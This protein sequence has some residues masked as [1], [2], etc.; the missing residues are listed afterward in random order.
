MRRGTGPTR[1]FFAETA[2]ADLDE[3]HR[4]YSELE[5]P[6]IADRLLSEIVRKVEQL[7]THPLSGRVVPEF[8]VDSLREVI[9]PPFR[10][11]YRVDPG[12]VR[13]VRVWRS[14]RRFDAPQASR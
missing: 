9:V 10:V 3:M 6:D 5:L 7:A 11:V 14:E 1:I 13:I 12:Y 2:A 4:H 8:A